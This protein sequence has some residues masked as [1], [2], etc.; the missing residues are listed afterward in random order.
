MTPFERIYEHTDRISSETAYS[1]A[2]CEFL[3]DLLMEVKFGGHVLEVG[4][5]YGRSTSVIIQQAHVRNLQVHLIDPME[6]PEARLSLLVMIAHRTCPACTLTLYKGYSPVA[7]PSGRD[8]F[9]LVHID[10]DHT[11]DA[12]KNDIIRWQGL[13]EPGGV[14][15]FH[16]YGRDSLPDV[17][18]A[19]NDYVVNGLWSDA[20]QRETLKAFR[21]VL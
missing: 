5:Q 14:M 2:E 13:V 21:R 10:A 16:D 15:C 11:Y 6:D 19:V 9:S 3:H 20:G 18:R 8:M 17:R 12:V 7:G 4:C 1:R